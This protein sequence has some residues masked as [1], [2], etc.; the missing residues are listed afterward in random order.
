MFFPL[1]IDSAESCPAYKEVSEPRFNPMF[2]LKVSESIIRVQDY[3]I[4]ELPGNDLTGGYYYVNTEECTDCNL[5]DHIEVIAPE[6]IRLEYKFDNESWDNA[7]PIDYGGLW[8]YFSGGFT[9][10]LNG[11]D[12]YFYDM[13][14]YWFGFNIDITGY[15]N[16]APHTLHIRSVTRYNHPAGS[17]FDAYTISRTIERSFDFS[18]GSPSCDCS[19]YGQGWHDA[20]FWGG[21]DDC[22]TNPVDWNNACAPCG[23][24]YA[25]CDGC[26][27]DTNWWNHKCA[28]SPKICTPYAQRC[29]PPD[30]G[31]GSDL[32]TCSSTGCSWN[33]A[34]DCGYHYWTDQYQCDATSRY[35]QRLYSENYCRDAEPACLS[36]NYWISIQDCGTDYWGALYSCNGN[37][38][39]RQYFD[40]GC[41]GA[42]CFSTPSYQNWENCDT[43][44][45]WYGSELRDYYC[46]SGV[47]AYSGNT[48]PNA[49][50]LVAPPH[51]T[52]I[53]YNPTFQ[54]TVS[55]PNNDQVRAYFEMPSPNYGNW[56][57]GSGTS[58][59]GPINLGSCISYWWRAYAQDEHG[60]WSLPSGYW[61]NKIDKVAP[62]T[63][64]IS[65]P[66]SVDEDGNI[67]ITLTEADSCSGIAEGDVEFRKKPCTAGSWNS[68]ANVSPSP[69]INDFVY[70]T[71][72]NNIYQFRYRVK[73]LAGNWS[74]FVEGPESKSGVIE[75]DNLEYVLSSQCRIAP[76][77]TFSWEYSSHCS[78][79]QSGFRIQIDNNSNFS[80]PEI[81]RT[82]SGTSNIQSVLLATIS[83]PNYLSFNTKYY[84]RVMVTS[85]GI[86][87]LWENGSSFTTPVH[88]YPIPGFTV[89]PQKPIVDETVQ[90]TDTSQCFDDVSTGSGCSKPNDTYSWTFENATP[91]SSVLEN[92]V[93]K[94]TDQGQNSITQQVTD[95]DG[96]SC[97][98]Q[99]YNVI[100]KLY[101]NY[102]VPTWKEI[103]PF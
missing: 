38:R 96:H 71:T 55:D 36:G 87:S 16:G 37:W 26:N 76:Y 67:A 39:T 13:N 91:G 90:F 11:T 63:V 2:I 97:T 92:P 60:L 49:P 42:S 102:P 54:A 56:V 99:D 30:I 12:V 52:W 34:Q 100:E 25:Y 47:C 7:T 88:H 31:T 6:V 20:P 78:G 27:W 57:S 51:N 84:W 28:G 44:D 1:R 48:P 22:T 29:D 50:T 9:G 64:D 69:G 86:S 4:G 103:L 14:R 15:L 83:T 10:C 81:D 65:Y 41:S 77:Y 17:T 61:L 62:E 79:D 53:N 5:I 21:C 18:G 73:D 94:F 45:G 95:S 89:E 85:G 23:E 19:G 35:V 24:A 68:W 40:Q 32:Y 33:F 59:Y 8:S 43:Y 82:V 75:A 93:V 58:S 70:H 74:E 46:S 66:A 101:I 98:N 80:S 3:T 72:Q